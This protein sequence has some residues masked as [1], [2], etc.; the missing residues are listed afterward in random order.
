MD[1]KLTLVCF[2]IL[3]VS[4]DFFFFFWCFLQRC[5]LQER[6]AYVTLKV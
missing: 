5:G 3:F 1:T 2:T 6:M 4:V